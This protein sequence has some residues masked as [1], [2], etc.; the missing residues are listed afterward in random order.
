MKYYKDSVTC[1]GSGVPKRDFFHVDDLANACVYLLEKWDPSNKNAP[2]DEQ[3]ES[4]NFLNI[5]TGL[6]ISIKELALLIAS[7]FEYKGKIIWD[8]SKPDGTPRKLL[9]ISKLKKL[10]WTAKTTLDKGIK[11]TLKSYLKD[12]ANKCIRQ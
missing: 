7:N 2:Q 4:L 8:L 11:L 9:D 1:W 6:D 12:F 10:G 3:G 5:G